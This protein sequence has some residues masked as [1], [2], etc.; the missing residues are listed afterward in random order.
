[1]SALA[2]VK[3]WSGVNRLLDR[4]DVSREGRRCRACSQSKSDT[5]T[6]SSA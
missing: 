3:A 1:M 6:G 4:P 5:R 2:A